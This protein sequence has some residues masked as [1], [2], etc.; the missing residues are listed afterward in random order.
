MDIY[1]CNSENVKPARIFFYHDDDIDLYKVHIILL[2]PQ[3]PV[4]KFNQ[5][6]RIAQELDKTGSIDANIIMKT[7]LEIVSTNDMNAWI[8]QEIPECD[9]TI[10]S[11]QVANLPIQKNS[12]IKLPA[13]VVPQKIAEQ[14][15]I[16]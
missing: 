3:I 1:K 12:E 13:F 6:L 9:M 2:V 11:R 16:F 7:G 14:R 8:T 10:R 4:N 15:H 5:N